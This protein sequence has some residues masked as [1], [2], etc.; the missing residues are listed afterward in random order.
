[1]LE[2]MLLISEYLSGHTSRPPHFPPRDLH[3]GPRVRMVKM[4]CY[5]SAATSMEGGQP[6]GSGNRPRPDAYI[7]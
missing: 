1:M 2:R 4:R 3:R 6:D 7:V 5:A